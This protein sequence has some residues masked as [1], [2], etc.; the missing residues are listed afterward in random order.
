MTQRLVIPKD[1]VPY[2]LVK[3][4]PVVI[5]QQERSVDIYQRSL[6]V[7]VL[8]SITIL[9]LLEICSR[10]GNKTLDAFQSE[11]N[12]FTGFFEAYTAEEIIPTVWK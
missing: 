6:N 4:H 7:A 10:I 1:H 5:P 12:N 8:L 9:W 2:S 3:N 11:P